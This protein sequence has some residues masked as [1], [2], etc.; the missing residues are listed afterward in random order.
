MG[1][2]LLSHL[3]Q[4]PVQVRALKRKKSNLAIVRKVLGYYHSDVNAVF[5]RIEWCEGDL[6]SPTFIQK[7]MQGMD[8]VYHCAAMVS[9]DP[10]I[11][12]EIYAANVGGTAAIVNE[13]LKNGIEKFCFV[14]SSAALGKPSG[15]NEALIDESTPW[16]HTSDLSD[17]AVSKYLAEQ[18]VWRGVQ[19]GLNVGCSVW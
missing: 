4:Q 15:R 8:Q 9:L 12:Q 3:L 19:E 5:R 11:R 16:E 14:S 13:S 17:Y 10:R 6:S 2:H 1:A 18:E 7:A